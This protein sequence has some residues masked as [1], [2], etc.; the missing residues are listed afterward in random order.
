MEGKTDKSKR[1]VNLR[2]RYATCVAAAKSN[3]TSKTSVF[4]EKRVKD[5]LTSIPEVS[6]RWRE[7]GMSVGCEV[8]KIGR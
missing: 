7:K 8:A 5:L 4:I 3:A 6:S 1:F 2:K